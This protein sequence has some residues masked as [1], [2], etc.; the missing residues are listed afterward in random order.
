[1]HAMNTTPDTPSAQTARELLRHTVATVAYRAGRA[2]RNAPENF[3]DFS[4][5]PKTR[6]PI[7]ILAHM[8]DLFD[9]ALSVAS[10][11]EKWHNSRPLEWEQEVERF[12]AA[13]EAFDKFLASDVPLGATAER[14]FQGPIADALTHVG[15]IALLRGLA[16]APIGGE[17]YSLAE[18]RAGRVGKQQAAAVYE[19][20]A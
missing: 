16:G 3:S 20:G 11:K 2:L 13:L 15:Q 7:Q 9:W 14:L 18:V 19:F 6:T 4:A 8:G 5:G 1:M 10:G 17:D 12:F